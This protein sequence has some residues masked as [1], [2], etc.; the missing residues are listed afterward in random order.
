MGVSVLMFIAAWKILSGAWSRLHSSQVPDVTSISF[1]IM[2][3]FVII[4]VGLAAWERRRSRRLSSTMIEADAGRVWGDTLV[5]M[6]VIGGLGTWRPHL[7]SSDP[8]RDELMAKLS[9]FG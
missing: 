8:L 2:M 7:E 1:V 3:G 4:S 6:S 5:S 9:L